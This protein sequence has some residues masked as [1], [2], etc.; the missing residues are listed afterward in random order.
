[1]TVNFSLLLFYAF[2]SFF[3]MS[4]GSC[5]PIKPTR[6]TNFPNLFCQEILHVSGSSSAH[7]QEFSTVHS[8]LVNVM[9]VWWQ[10]SST[11]VIK[12]AWHIPVP[13]VQ[14]KTP[15]DGQ[16]N[17]TKHVEF[18]DKNKL[19]KL[20][21]LLVL[22]ETDLLRCTVT[23]TLSSSLGSPILGSAKWH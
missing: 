2:N 16:R 12:T 3:E 13:N 6:C 7:H 15:D 11:T 5:F 19:G 23:W 9:Q 4:L 8:A 18:P 21:R 10:L 22:L 20:V 14:W 17:C 1:M